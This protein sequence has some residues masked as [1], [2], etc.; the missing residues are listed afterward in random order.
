M[1]SY[2]THIKGYQVDTMLR[3]AYTAFGE[4]VDHFI[5]STY[6]SLP[7]EISVDTLLQLCM[8]V[9]SVYIIMHTQG[10]TQSDNTCPLPGLRQGNYIQSSLCAGL[11]ILFTWR[12]IFSR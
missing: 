9:T 6:S 11:Q 5:E 7:V 4:S 10:V 1:S 12:V 2:I 8:I 3:D